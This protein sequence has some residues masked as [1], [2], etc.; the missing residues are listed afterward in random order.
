M[1]N[2]RPDDVGFSPMADL[3]FMEFC[4]R[5]TFQA[6]GSVPHMFTRRCFGIRHFGLSTALGI[7]FF[8]AL[9]RSDD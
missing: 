9:L 5:V 6:L 4:F 7:G 2:S 1:N 3:R 8:L